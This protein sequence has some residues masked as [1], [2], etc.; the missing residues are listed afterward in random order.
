EAAG[1]SPC[2][3]KG[4]KGGTSFY[5]HGG[6]NSRSF[7]RNGQ[8]VAEIL[9]QGRLV[10]L[11]PTIHPDTG[12]PYVWTTPQRLLNRDPATLPTLNAAGIAALL[13]PERQPTRRREAA[14]RPA[15]R[16]RQAEAALLAEA[17]RHISP[18]CDYGTW[19]RIGMSLKASNL[20]DAVSFDLW[21]TW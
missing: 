19:L 5:R 9:S 4:K 2:G 7:S 12:K 17:L 15:T 11:P 3:K 14:P 21:N 13:E 8:V 10:I 6:E 1:P 16:D 18:D 20:P